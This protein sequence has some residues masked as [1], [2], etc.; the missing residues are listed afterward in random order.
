MVMYLIGVLCKGVAKLGQWSLL[1]ASTQEEN[2]FVFDRMS[3][4]TRYLYEYLPSYTIAGYVVFILVFLLSALVYKLGFAKQLS[5]LQ[6]I[7][8]Y[9][10][11]FVGCIV[12]T[13]LALFLPMVEGLIVAALILIVYKIRMHRE[14]KEE[15]AAQ[16]NA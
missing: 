15:M 8:I 14:K 1:F 6:N 13:F 16:K 3:G 5:L 7:I 2:A 4:I 10:F 9:T 11:L 12:L